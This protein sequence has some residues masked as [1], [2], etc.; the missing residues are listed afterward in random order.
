LPV[1]WPWQKY[2]ELG[3]AYG[4]LIHFHALGQ[5]ILVINSHSDA[6]ELLNKR[7]ISNGRAKIHMAGEMMGWERIIGLS[8]YGTHWRQ[9]RKIAH[10]Y[11]NKT[12]ISRFH[13]TQLKQSRFFLQ[14]LLDNP[15]SFR[16]GFRLAA[17][18]GI[19][20]T[21]YGL[22]IES[23]NDRFLALSQ[24]GITRLG[25]AIIPGAYLV[26]ILPLLKHLPDWFPGAGFKRYAKES[27]ALTDEM[28]DWP[29]EKVK[30]DLAAGTALPSMTSL[31]LPDVLGNE[32]QE[33]LLK[34]M[35]A[36][37]YVGGADT[38]ASTME[39]FFLAMVLYPRVLKAAQAEV[40]RVIGP[41]RLPTF[42]DRPRL[43]YIN[44]MVKEILRWHPVFPL[45]VHHRSN[46]DDVYKGYFIPSGTVI[47]PNVWAMCRD[48]EMYP[49][50]DEFR[51]ERFLEPNKSG[52][53]P[54]D[55]EKYIFGF[56]RRV[57]VGSHY[58]D[59]VL[60]IMI[61]SIVATF[62]ISKALDEHGNEITP[63]ESYTNSLMTFPERFDC[64]IT[65][66]SNDAAALIRDETIAVGI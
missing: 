9:M 24:S 23:W 40:D 60:F 58:A 44:A 25:E 14:C 66:R 41:D 31:H 50:P 57:C 53:L 2:R 48:E 33:Y 30:A 8:D 34:W 32:E 52:Q 19:M 11:L 4:N 6:N 3:Q 63:V 39:S 17:A 47:L 36:S 29:F 13:P 21:T 28:A 65:P 26:D 10:R 45:G 27:R 64:T 1:E 51:P 16:Q 55:P 37:M 15:T 61:S 42:E 35:G 49:K 62:D 20:K 38:S 7:A 59:A 56:G 46:V 54:L 43:P 22:D 12:V 18:K 5:H